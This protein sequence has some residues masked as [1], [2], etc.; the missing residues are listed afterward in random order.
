M[1][2]SAR[3]RLGQREQGI[4][5]PP[6]L[7]AGDNKAVPVAPHLPE[8]AAQPVARP[9]GVIGRWIAVEPHDVEAG[10]VEGTCE[11]R[12]LQTAIIDTAI[13]MAPDQDAGGGCGSVPD[14][15]VI[16][17]EGKTGSLEQ[18]PGNCW[19][20]R[21]PRHDLQI[22]CI[23]CAVGGTAGG[24]ASERLT[25][26]IIDRAAAGI[27]ADC[28]SRGDGRSPRCVH[29]QEARIARPPMRV[30]IRNRSDVEDRLCSGNAHS[31]N[32]RQDDRPQH[33]PALIYAP[34]NILSKRTGNPLKLLVPPVSACPTV[35]GLCLDGPAIC[36]L[37]GLAFF[38]E[39]VKR[40]EIA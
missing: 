10:I 17:D 32:A 16:G 18:R 27:P 30:E 37:R 2:P 8:P 26:R 13:P 40:L 1:T 19:E 34:H 7:A 29:Q 22:I 11:R 35:T 15:S 31:E 23:N 25:P 36:S 21:R 9:V 3:P 5:C 33:F 14:E 28:P 38:A 4:I 39:L 24:A 12:W 6:G 20:L